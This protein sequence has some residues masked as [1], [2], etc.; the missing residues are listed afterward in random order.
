MKNYR[1]TADIG[2]CY[3]ETSESEVVRFDSA[4]VPGDLGD[5]ME[6]TSTR[7]PEMEPIEYAETM[8]LSEMVD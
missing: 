1:K 5:V 4:A 2:Y 7:F 3:S 8:P 6:G